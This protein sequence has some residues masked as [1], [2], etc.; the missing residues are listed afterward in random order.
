MKWIVVAACVSLVVPVA[1]CRGKRRTQEPD[2]VAATV[3]GVPIPLRPIQ[4][5]TERDLAK[6]AKF[7]M[8]PRSAETEA[9]QRQQRLEAAIQ[10]ELLAQASASVD[11]PGLEAEV[12][13]QLQ[14]MAAARPEG[15]T[16]A[17]AIDDALRAKVRRKVRIERYL[18]LAGLATPPVAEDQIRRI[19]DANRAS[20]A[21][22]ASLHVRHVLVKVG[23]AEERDAARAKAARVLGEIRS[24]KLGIE[25]AARKYSD[26]ESAEA[27]GDL[28]DVS[29]GYLPEPL[30]RAVL[31]LRPGEIA[32]PIET[33]FGFHVAQL[34]ESKPPYTPP[35]AD[36]RDFIRRYLEDQE[37]QRLVAAHVAQLRASARVEVFVR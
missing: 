37:R 1:G 34:V 3:N 22:P 6:K 25:E 2:P 23:A 12:D 16:Q 20:F 14:A 8:D 35:Y 5:A 11:A 30:E 18:K 28:G 31:A 19:Y 26:C 4:A 17:P 24:G 33:K 13:A 36:A 10:D 29:K 27:G 7:G 9:R 15:D 21:R 32:G